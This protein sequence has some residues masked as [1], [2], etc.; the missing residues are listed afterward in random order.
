MGV[1]GPGPGS[2]QGQGCCLQTPHSHRS[3][4]RAPTTPPQ[5]EFEASGRPYLLQRPVIQRLLRHAESGDKR[6]ISL[7]GWTGSGKSAALY[8]LVSWARASGWIALYVPSAFSMVQGGNFNRGEDGLFDMPQGA[9][10]ILQSMLQ[11]HEADLKVR[12]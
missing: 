8:A 10:Y 7:Q 6:Q 12:G 11:T 5:R 2:R 9:R 4:G 1:D 3:R